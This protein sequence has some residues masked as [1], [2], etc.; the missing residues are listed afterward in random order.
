MIINWQIS[1]SLTTWWTHNQANEQGAPIVVV[2]LDDVTMA[3]RGGEMVKPKEKRQIP[4]QPSQNQHKNQT[5]WP[6]R[7]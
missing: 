5:R 4:Q 2:V 7:V 1:R 3:W 6:W